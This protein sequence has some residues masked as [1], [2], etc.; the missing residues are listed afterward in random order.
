MGLSD[1]GQIPTRFGTVHNPSALGRAYEAQRLKRYRTIRANCVKDHGEIDN[2]PDC[3]KDKGR[4]TFHFVWVYGEIDKLPDCV[5][6]K[7][8]FTFHF[9]S[10]YGEIGKLPGCA[11]YGGRSTFHFVWVYSEI[12]KL[13]NCPSGCR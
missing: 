5:K 7:G 9:V 13:P 2:F 12:E 3:K 1:L 10:V 8:R 11:K 6:D 4:S